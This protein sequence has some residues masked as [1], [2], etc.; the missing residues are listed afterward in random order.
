MS[1]FCLIGLRLGVSAVGLSKHFQVLKTDVFRIFLD[2][3]YVFRV[4]LKPLINQPE[5]P[6]LQLLMAQCFIDSFE[7]K[8]TVII[9]CLELYTDLR[10]I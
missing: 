6:E 8:I 2:M 5:R 4:Y 1:S 7:R 3:L 9:D 10:E